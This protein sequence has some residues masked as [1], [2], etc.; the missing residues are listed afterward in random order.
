M[1]ITKFRA[2]IVVSGV[3]K[4][5][6]ED[7]WAELRVGKD[8]TVK[9]TQN[10][11]RCATLNVNYATGKSG[12]SEAGRIL[13]ML[14]KDRRVDPGAKWSPIFGKYGFVV[15]T[16]GGADGVIIK[17]GDEVQ[18]VKRNSERTV[19][20]KSSSFTSCYMTADLKNAYYPKS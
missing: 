4:P 9:L 2:N 5:Y 16:T 11:A 6:E 18:V 3:E 20:G 1:D 15:S 12:E 17:V 7:F 14:S 10:C 8:I 19:T 13:K